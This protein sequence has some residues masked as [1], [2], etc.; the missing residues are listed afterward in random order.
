MSSYLHALSS[1]NQKDK[2]RSQLWLKYSWYY[3]LKKK[4]LSHRSLLR[5]H[6]VMQLIT[7]NNDLIGNTV[8]STGVFLVMSLSVG[9]WYWSQ[10]T[11]NFIEKQCDEVL[12]YSSLP[13]NWVSRH[14]FRGSGSWV[15]I[16]KL[17][18]SIKPRVTIGTIYVSSWWYSYW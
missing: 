4:K 3:S 6:W 7:L 17:F 2:T 1:L 8:S 9:C 5:G 11:S 18:L 15:D 12:E 14:S 10:R 13:S 16:H